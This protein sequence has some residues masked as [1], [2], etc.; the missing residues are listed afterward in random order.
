MNTITLLHDSASEY[1]AIAEAKISSLKWKKKEELAKLHDSKLKHNSDCDLA[2]APYLEYFKSD[3]YKNA[4]DSEL[5]KDIKPKWFW[6]RRAKKEQAEHVKESVHGMIKRNGLNNGAGSYVRVIFIS[7]ISDHSMFN[8]D[9][10]HGPYSKIIISEFYDYEPKIIKAFL[11]DGFD[12]KKYDKEILAVEESIGMLK[13]II[14]HGSAIVDIDWVVTL[15]NLK[16][17]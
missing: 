2:L 15:E 9:M 14:K 7:K 5:N 16:C 11:R 12:I 4:V 3:E 13:A 1:L 10:N 17:N 6:L 8:P